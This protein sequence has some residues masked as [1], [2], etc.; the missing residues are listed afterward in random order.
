MF[1]T[2]IFLA[3]KI[4]IYGNIR[5][6]IKFLNSNIANICIL[7]VNL[8]DCLFYLIFRRKKIST[9]SKM[10]ERCVSK[11]FWKV[12]IPILREQLIKKNS[13]FHLGQ[14]SQFILTFLS[15]YCFFFQIVISWQNANKKFRNEIHFLL[16]KLN[17]ARE[18]YFF[19]YKRN[20]FL[21]RFSLSFFTPQDEYK[22]C[23]IQRE[24][25]MC[26]Y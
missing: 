24:N 6:I 9:R 4:S 12:I 11:L 21:R 3:Q 15:I 16:A 17:S 19:S 1:Y 22:F 25:A 7:S 2:F 23:S 8:T 10:M 20:I 26:L 13:D 18:S 14:V 5:C